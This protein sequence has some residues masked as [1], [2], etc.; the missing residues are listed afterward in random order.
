[1]GQQAV[2]QQDT[3]VPLLTT[4]LQ[5]INDTG[6]QQ[7]PYAAQVYG[8][9]VLTTGQQSSSIQLFG[10]FMVTVWGAG[11][12]TGTFTVDRS[13]DGGTTWVIAVPY[14]A[15]GES[16]TGATAGIITVP[17]VVTGNTAGIT[18][19]YF[20]PERNVLFRVNAVS[21]TGTFNFRIAQSTDWWIGFGRSS[22]F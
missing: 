5:P 10:W 19:I 18:A 1:M 20:E 3:A 6:V 21:A 8:A 13:F 16:L 11:M 14:N 4:Q 22:S 12:A 15:T 9:A 17:T 7:P 2:G